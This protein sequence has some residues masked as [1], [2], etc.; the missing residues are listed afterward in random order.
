MH[1]F[2]ILSRRDSL[3]HQTR[4]VSVPSAGIA[5]PV[6]DVCVI[7]VQSGRVSVRL[8]NERI[9]VNRG[10]T[11]I[12]RHSNRDLCR[13]DGLHEAICIIGDIAYRAGT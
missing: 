9:E 11:A 10:D 4:R 8:G 2:N 3:S 12:A 5:H 6:G 1:D 7:Y 13:I